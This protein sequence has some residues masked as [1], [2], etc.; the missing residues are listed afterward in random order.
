MTRPAEVI[1]GPMLIGFAINIW[2]L[3]VITTQTYLYYTRYKDDKTWIKV[4]VAVLFALNMANTA[5]LL[6]YLYQALIIFY[7]DLN[8]L[9]RTNW[10]FGVGD[11]ILTGTITTLVQIFFAR[12][13]FILT[14]KWIW[15]ILITIPAVISGGAALVVPFIV[16]QVPYFAELRRA[17]RWNILWLGSGVVADIFI[18][19]ILVYHLVSLV[20]LAAELVNNSDPQQTHKSGVRRSDVLVDRIIRFTIETGLLTVVVAIL[21]MVFFLTNTNGVHILLTFTLCKLYSVSLMS[22]LNARRQWERSLYTPNMEMDSSASMVF[23]N[24]FLSQPCQQVPEVKIE[25]L[26][27]A[28]SFDMR[29]E[30]ESVHIQAVHRGQEE[31]FKRNPCKSGSLPGSP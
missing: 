4:F 2:M 15:F 19:C 9:K 10:V 7:G 22:S 13:V 24:G 17:A 18:T 14:G 21:D 27:F 11:P 31:H 23:G 12:R 30:L 25:P 6:L 5:L 16:D 8:Y 26:Q 28:T 1:H 29:V 3:G 20:I